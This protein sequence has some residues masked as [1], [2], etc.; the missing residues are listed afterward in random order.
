MQVHM[1][2]LLQ[3]Q[4]GATLVSANLNSGYDESDIRSFRA[5]LTRLRDSP[6]RLVAAYVQ[7]AS[8]LDAYGDGLVS[9]EELLSVARATLPQLV[10]ATIQT[11]R[12][13][14]VELGELPD[15]IAA[16]R[17]S[18]RVP[19][20][21]FYSALRL[22][23][24]VLLRH[25]REVTSSD[26]FTAVSRCAEIL[27][28]TVDNFVVQTHDLYR[29]YVGAAANDRRFQSSRLISRLFR[30]ESEPKL[31]Q[32]T[33]DVA[34]SLGVSADSPFVVCSTAYDSLPAIRRLEEEMHQRRL[35]FFVLDR[36]MDVVFFWP[37]ETRSDF[38][39]PQTSGLEALN[40]IRFGRID[41]VPG[42]ISVPRAAESARKTL[43]LAESTQMGE[44]KLA[45]VWTAAAAS[46]LNS[47]SDDFTALCEKITTLPDSRR[48]RIL[49]VVKAYLETS[50]I[51]ETAT[52]LYLH[53]N[54]VMNYMGEF[55]DAT[56]LVLR[57][58]S[59]A[60]L[61]LLVIRW[62]ELGDH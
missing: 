29:D 33:D 4:R 39:S 20:N 16:N 37:L 62:I 7:R 49:E 46:A 52:K 27:W 15:R 23:F 28:E 53:R 25:L 3:A 51:T 19:D 8:E 22:N 38:R 41:S 60:A 56:G 61:A 17:A 12:T 31:K 21:D 13:G 45:D 47:L 43:A 42:L 26:E 58:T 1:G 54:T 44:V 11:T 30:K 50:S 57:K 59:Q 10:E 34:R 14:Q 32:I 18:L 40:A 9:N 6:D 5:A 55:S 35:K 2:P 48:D 24:I 36:G